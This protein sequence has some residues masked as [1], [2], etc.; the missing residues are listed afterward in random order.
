VIAGHGRHPPRHAP[1]DF[2]MAVSRACV[3]L[4]A[5]N[6]RGCHI[7]TFDLS[8]KTETPERL[9]YVAA[10]ELILNGRS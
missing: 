4:T 5:I 7:S 10:R 1:N 3:L 9:M 2:E 6:G 8:L